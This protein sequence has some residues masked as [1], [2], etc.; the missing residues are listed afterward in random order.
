MA[1]DELLQYVGSEGKFQVLTII[2]FMLLN[3]LTQPHDSIENFTAAI[4]AHHCHVHL[5]DNPTFKTNITINLTTEALL[6]VSI[7]VGPNQKPEQCRRFLQTQW[8]LLDPNISAINHTDPE[9]EPCLDGWIYDQSVF[10]STIITKWDLV[11]DYQS[12]KYFTQAFAQ[13]GHLVGC[14]LSGI[15]SDRFGRKP[16]LVFCC[17]TYGI[18]STCCAFAPVFIIYG[19]LRFLTSVCLSAILNNS[20]VFILEGSSPK[21]KL[22]VTTLFSLSGTAGQ[23]L[24][25]GLAYFFRDW[26]MLQL[27]IA[28]PCLIL[29][30]F[31]CGIS[32][33]IRWL[34]ATGKTEQALKEL[35]RIARINGKKEVAKSLT[36]EVLISN[37]KEE[38]NTTRE[39]SGIKDVV[40]NPVVFKTVFFIGILG[41]SA[42][43]S[44]YGLLLDVDNLGKNIFLTQFLLGI[45][46]IPSKLLSYFILKNINRR[47]SSSFSLF[48][49][50]GFILLTIFV[51]KEM[52]VLRLI[53]FLLGKSSVSIYMSIMIIFTNELSPTVLRS[54]MQGIL[55]FLARAAAT[56]SALVLSTRIYFVHLPAIL[57]AVF[58]MAVSVFV[59]FLPES[60]NLPLIDTIEDMEKRYK[61]RNKDTQT[62]QRKDLLATSEC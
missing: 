12:F 15:V 10:T 4:P 56:L 24:L 6:R 23:I 29:S 34:M 13:S 38:L 53:L 61:F 1:F 11:C 36:A 59:Y 40:F 48:M 58:P 33:S 8:Q 57:Y 27:A 47:P 44:Y 35:Q 49:C 26:Q 39:P 22:V 7:P 46:D 19:I 60:F 41:C 14:A 25:A 5:L 18:L 28:L 16:L 21:W 52:H 2:F 51:S 3:I 32:E 17:L 54:T 42:T 50:G 30:L 45:S 9:T 43:F 37:M 31:V 20:L 55:F 62:K